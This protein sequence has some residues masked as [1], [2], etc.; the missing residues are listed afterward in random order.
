MDIVR[1]VADELTKEGV[2][3]VMQKGNVI[4]EGATEAVGPIRLRKKT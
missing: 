3:V 4:A 2:L 1:E